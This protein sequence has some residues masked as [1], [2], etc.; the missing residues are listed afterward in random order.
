MVDRIG[1]GCVGAAL[2]R[3]RVSSVKLPARPKF[4]IQV[5]QIYSG[6]QHRHRYTASVQSTAFQAGNVELLRNVHMRPY[7][8]GAAAGEEVGDLGIGEN[9]PAV[10]AGRNLLA[11]VG[12]HKSTDGKGL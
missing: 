6:I 11:A 2:R 9:R 4:G 12:F 3:P 10:H 8:R 1:P 7:R 5:R